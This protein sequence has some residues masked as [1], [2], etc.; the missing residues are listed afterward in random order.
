MIYINQPILLQKCGS[1]I[2][3]VSLIAKE[4]SPFSRRE[5]FSQIKLQMSQIPD[6]YQSAFPCG[7][8]I[9]V[10]TDIHS[11]PTHDKRI[12][13]VVLHF[14][15]FRLELPIMGFIGLPLRLDAVCQKL[16]LGFAVFAVRLNLC[17][18]TRGID[19]KIY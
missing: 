2:F 5:F 11:L 18:K 17:R 15:K 14:K 13:L 6:Q 16:I 8:K 10:N 3:V 7:V 12:I 4:L 9:G 19:W 1:K